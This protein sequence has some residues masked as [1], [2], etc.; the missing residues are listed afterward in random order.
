ME[1]TPF[2]YRYDPFTGEQYRLR[3]L[4]KYRRVGEDRDGGFTV[5]PAH[6]EIE[7]ITAIGTPHQYLAETDEDERAAIEEQ[8]VDHFRGV[9]EQAEI[10]AYEERR[11]C[12]ADSVLILQAVQGW[13][14]VGEGQPSHAGRYYAWYVPGL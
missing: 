9:L 12:D 7:S 13:E 8:M 6:C 5:T 4:V 1:F 11:R 14:R 2:V 3:L 10:E